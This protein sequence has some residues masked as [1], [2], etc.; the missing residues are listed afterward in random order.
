ML[1]PVSMM[2]HRVDL[3][4]DDSDTT[5]F[6]HLLYAGE[7]ITK[8]VTAALVAAVSD[9]REGHRYRLTHRLIRADG[10]GEWTQT[11][12]EVLGGPPAQHLLETATEDRRSL[13]ERFRSGTW[14]HEAVD[15]LLRALRSLAV[16]ADAAPARVPLRQWFAGFVTLR[17]STRGHGA[18]TPEVCARL[19]SDLEQ[20]I[21]LIIDQLHILQ[22]PWAYLHRNLSGKFRVIPLS[23]DMAS[24]EQLKTTA[25]AAAFRHRNM[26]DGVYVDFHEFAKVDLIDTS[27]DVAD[28]F[29]PNGGFRGTSFELLS[30]ISDN[31]KQGDASPYLK[32][33]GERPNRETEGKGILEIVGQAWTNI[34]PLSVGYVLRPA[35]EDELYQALHDDRHPVITLVGSGG[36][37]KTSLAISV[38]NRVANEGKFEV[39]VWLSARDVDLLPEGPKVVTPR[40]L[41]QADIAN[42]LVGLLEPAEAA[43]G[44]FKP[45]N[46]LAEALRRSPTG[47]PMLFVFDNFET[48]RSP[49]DLFEWLDTQIR[50]PNKILITTR[51]REFK[52]DYPIEI[53]GMTET[54]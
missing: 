15:R 13:T 24:F 12:E 36:I 47:K 17:N 44:E 34:P 52:A 20:S 21:K 22:R 5:F 7:M 23:G 16:N 28:F 35:P 37:G 14:Q 10:L 1:L 4:R 39:I 29:F 48:V 45:L 19:S 9:D 32:P 40:V 54:C 6:L 30:L 31:R 18:T 26:S 3:A 50:L 2:W 41:T 38:V 8:L 49:G 25:G 42:Q 51:Y 11:L 33:A 43:T 46:Y 53:S 27:I